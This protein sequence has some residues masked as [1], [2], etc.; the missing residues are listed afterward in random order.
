MRDRVAQLESTEPKLTIKL[1]FN[2]K[3]PIEI[4]SIAPLENQQQRDL[5]RQII[6]ENPP[7][8][9]NAWM[10][11]RDYSYD[12]RYKK[13]EEKIVPLHVGRLNKFLETF[14]GQLRF[15]FSVSNVGHIQAE[16]L[17]VTLRAVGGTLHDRFSAFPIFGPTPPRFRPGILHSIPRFDNII[18]ASPGR[19]DMHFSQGPDRAPIIEIQCGDFRQGRSWNFAGI[20]TIDPSFISPLKIIATVSAANMRGSI[21]ELYELP[22]K[23]S[24]VEVENLIDLSEGKWLRDFPLRSQFDEAI[25]KNNLKWL[26]ILRLKANGK[27]TDDEY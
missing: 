4:F 22:F 6:R 3:G 18:P 24:A 27:Y 26:H 23:A 5:A 14:F 11:D 1:A 17:V 21:S 9:Q 16:H 13:W 2:E 8:A 15:Q 20:V 19:H 7:R 25:A 10:P 12:D